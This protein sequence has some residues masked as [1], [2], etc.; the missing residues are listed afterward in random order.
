MFRDLIHGVSGI[1]LNPSKRSL[2]YS[3]LCPRVR[4]L[5]LASFEA[6]YR[7]IVED[8]AG[9]E[10]ARMLDHVTTN[11][12]QFFREPQHFD[13]LETTLLPAWTEAARRGAREKRIRA[14]SAGCS[15]GEEPYSLAML[16][17]AHCRKELGWSIDIVATD[18]SN[19]VLAKARE[20]TWPIAKASQIPR[21]FLKRFMLRGIGQKTGTLR[22]GPELREVVRFARKN[23]NDEESPSSGVFDII[24]CRNVLI[25]FE[26]EGRQRVIERL[27]DR[28]AIGGRLFLGHAESIHGLM[29]RLRC[30][31]ATQYAKET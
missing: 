10:L 17:L 3:R 13:Y 14:W 8:T 22:A 31:G 29:G 16:L 28:L 25:Y 7:C 15:T 27:A 19:R 11:E 30:V 23:L 6:Y 26:G 20:A 18:L 24:F 2:L 1:H 9:L 21:G 4:E 5:K 12:T